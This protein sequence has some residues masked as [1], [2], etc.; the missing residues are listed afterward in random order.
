MKIRFFPHAD[1]WPVKKLE[2]QGNVH[3][4][5][6]AVLFRTIS[7]GKALPY[8][9]TNLL[10]G[11]PDKGVTDRTACLGGTVPVSQTEDSKKLTYVC[12]KHSS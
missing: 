12:Y 2:Q 5:E 10:P 4:P 8:L 9:L 1:R 3:P 11:Y 6:S 7:S